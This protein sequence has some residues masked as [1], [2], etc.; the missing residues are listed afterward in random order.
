MI[1]GATV[2]L[3]GYV[4]TEP[5]YKTIN[6]EIPHVSMRVAWTSRYRDRETGEW[7]DGK[8]S[9]ANVN[10]WRKLAN[11]VV[12]SL[13]KGQAIV[14][15]GRLQ[16]RD[17]D[18]RD[19]KRRI[20]VDIEADAIGH[21]LYRGVAHFQRT[22][23]SGGEAAAD[24]QPDG[25]AMGEAIRAGLTDDDVAGQDTPDLAAAESAARNG[26]GAAGTSDDMFNAEAIGE[27]AGSAEGAAAAAAPF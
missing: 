5:H 7:R 15:M 14:V 4:A 20:A 1:N 22:F 17:F 25:L 23:R 9:F 27:L 11:N 2:T 3:A 21:D 24:G 8:T 19:G 18:D 12:S 26:D 6:D 10:C 13:R 16:V